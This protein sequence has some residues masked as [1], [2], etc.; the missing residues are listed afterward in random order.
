[1]QAI[2]QSIDRSYF[3]R[4][5]AGTDPLNS[6]RNEAGTDVQFYRER[7]NERI[8]SFTVPFYQKSRILGSFFLSF[9]HIFAKWY[10]FSACFQ[11]Y[12][13]FFV[14]IQRDRFGI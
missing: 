4:N 1:M 8:R 6:E 11:S 2:D 10:C 13:A 3:L 5:E 9:L 12:M 7:K 14:K